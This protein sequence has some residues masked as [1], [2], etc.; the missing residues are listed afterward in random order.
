MER[1]I[2]VAVTAG[3]SVVVTSRWGNR[4]ARWP[5]SVEQVPHAPV[6]GRVV[7]LGLDVDVRVRPQPQL[8][9]RS[10]TDWAFVAKAR[11]STAAAAT[12]TVATVR[13]NARTT[14]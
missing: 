6:P 14:L 7:V 3:R 8:Q 10:G 13:R 2:V 1:F 5:G 9:P 11:P 12:T 4:I